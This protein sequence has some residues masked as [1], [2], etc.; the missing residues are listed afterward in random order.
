MLA[1]V[2]IDGENFRNSII[3]LFSEDRSV[4]EAPFYRDDYFAQGGALGRF[5]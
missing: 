5:V 4:A 2:F 3:E 1:C